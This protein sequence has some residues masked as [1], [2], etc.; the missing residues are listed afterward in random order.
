MYIRKAEIKNFKNIEHLKLDFPNPAGWHVI[1]GDNGAG[2][3][4]ILRA[5]ALAL[6]AYQLFPL[7]IPS[8]NYVK[9][10]ATADAKVSLTLEIDPLFDEYDKN[11]NSEQL[12]SINLSIAQDMD[13]QDYD[14]NIKPFLEDSY[15]SGKDVKAYSKGWFSAGYGPLRR[16]TGGNT[17][18]DKIYKSHPKLSAHLSLFGEDIALTQSL[19]WLREL[20]YK[21]LEG[22][23]KAKTTLNN[24]RKFINQGNLLPEEAQIHSVSSEGIMIKDRNNNLI[25]IT[26]MSDGFRSILSLTLELIRQLVFNYGP[27]LIFRTI[28]NGE[29]F[30][31]APGVV[32]IDEVDAHLHPS[33]QARIGE[34]FLKYF[35]Q[36]QFIVTTHS[37]I[38]CRAAEH[39]SIWRLATSGSDQR[40]YQVE[41]IERKRL[42]YGNILDA[43]STGLFGEDTSSSDETTQLLEELALLNKKSILGTIN[44]AEDNRRSE[45]IEILPTE[46]AG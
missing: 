8:E 32:L 35:P 38:I 21:R 42:I 37:P 22:N 17:E 13:L 6:G 45:L 43:Y 14:G 7:W 27:D 39:G 31:N 33:W 11:I 9:I 12:R 20:N 3:T 30:I 26:E 34:W 25:D 46:Q 15:N 2:K 40:A 19:D 23:R 4:S 28:E 18:R 5:L 10:G 1:I 24:V 41:G 16:F 29:Y 36:I 44:R